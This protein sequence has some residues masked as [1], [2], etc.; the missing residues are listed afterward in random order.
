MPDRL[1]AVAP[2]DTVILL[3]W[4]GGAYHNITGSDP[5]SV[6]TGTAPLLTGEIRGQIYEGT[7]GARAPLDGATIEVLNGMVLGKRATSGVAP[8]PHPG[9]TTTFI[10]PG[11]YRILGVPRGTFR[12]R[13][14]KDGYFDEE[15]D[16]SAST[17]SDFYLQRR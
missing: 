7:P 4:S 17:S 5:V 8:A 3:T 16:V 6:F 14:T 9:M 2:G 10:Q 11:M 12:V 13:V 15:R 1:E